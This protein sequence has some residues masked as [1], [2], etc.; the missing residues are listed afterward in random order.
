MI[1][2]PRLLYVYYGR[3]VLPLSVLV[4]VYCVLRLQHMFDDNEVVL[5]R[6]YVFG[7]CV[8]LFVLLLYTAQVVESP[9]S[10]RGQ[11]RYVVA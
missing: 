7:L 8:V 4:M 6:R 1:K 9:N 2:T 5:Y 3:A 11:K 10:Q